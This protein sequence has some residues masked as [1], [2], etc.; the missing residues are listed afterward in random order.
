MLQ[1]AP[2]CMSSCTEQ[3]EATNRHWHVWALGARISKDRLVRGRAEN[4]TSQYVAMASRREPLLTCSERVRANTMQAQASQ[5]S[6]SHHHRVNGKNS[7]LRRFLEHKVSKA[8]RRTRVG[9][10]ACVGDCW[11]LSWEHAVQHVWEGCGRHRQRVRIRLQVV[12]VPARLQS[13]R[14]RLRKS[15]RSRWRLAEHDPPDAIVYETRYVCFLFEL[16]VDV[17]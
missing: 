17:R 12:R 14:R 3:L 5:L 2:A 16:Y 1:H 9:P 13:I 4:E 7:L 8:T 6:K 11:M 10:M 15:C